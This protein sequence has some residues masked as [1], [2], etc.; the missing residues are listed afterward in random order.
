MG[1]TDSDFISL[2]AATS[3]GMQIE[4]ANEWIDIEYRPQHMV[5]NFGTMLELLTNGAV[6]AVRHRVKMIEEGERLS[7]GIFVNADLE[8]FVY[9]S[10]NHTLV[11]VK[12]VLQHFQD[13]FD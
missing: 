7:F 5:I 9:R 12:T 1:H 2:I 4:Y 3:G 6:K 10:Q 8:G 11:P 13:S